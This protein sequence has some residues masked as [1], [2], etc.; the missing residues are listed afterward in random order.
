MSLKDQILEVKEELTQEEKFFESTVK[1]ERFLKKYKG[2]IIA[3]TLLIAFILV[4]LGANELYN[5]NR[6]DAAN[7]AFLTLQKD[8]N[9]SKAIE[10]LKENS[11]ELYALWLYS[12][13][14]PIDITEYETKWLFD[15][16][17]A[18]QKASAS[19]SL[20][21][22]RSYAMRPN[23]IYKDLALYESAYLLVEAEKFDEA[24]QQIEAI[25]DDSVLAS[26]ANALCHLL[27]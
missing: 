15:D 27:H 19:R 2:F 5:N 11:S 24:K 16:L 8:A 23:A 17:N 3:S 6:V 26:E 12:Q 10:I 1:A 13:K 21:A 4:G 9:N 14:L 22:L 7:M 20:E 18:Y 25:S